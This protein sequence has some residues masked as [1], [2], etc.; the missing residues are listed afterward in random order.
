MASGTSS[1]Q[2]IIQKFRNLRGFMRFKSTEET[3]D[4][5][6]PVR[7]YLTYSIL[8]IEE[9]LQPVSNRIDHFEQHIR[10][11]KHSCHFPS[12]HGLTRDESASIYIYTMEWGETSLYRLLNADQRNRNRSILTPWYSYLKLL[13]SALD[14][15]PNKKGNFWRGINVKF[16]RAYEK[17]D[18]QTWWCLTSCSAEVSQVKPF[19]GQQST[20]MSIEAETAK[21]ISIYSCYPFEKEV[22]LVFGTG[23]RVLSNTLEHESLSLVQ[24]REV[25]AKKGKPGW[26]TAIKDKVFSEVVKNKAKKRLENR[27]YP[28][29]DTYDLAIFFPGVAVL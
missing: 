23:V 15:L 2:T 6:S 21:E 4:D 27:T 25:V 16:V 28:N 12:E 9:A 8:T 22:V 17:G 20:L 26:I 14:K 19:L 18:L 13:S 1:P 10:E 5:F 11:A 7:K 3:M 29:G 24:L